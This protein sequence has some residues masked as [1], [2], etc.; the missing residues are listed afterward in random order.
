MIENN[1]ITDNIMIMDNMIQD[2]SLIVNLSSSSRT[3]AIA[4]PD[5][6]DTSALLPGRDSAQARALDW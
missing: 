1:L 3:I 4:T 5:L 6:S 2:A